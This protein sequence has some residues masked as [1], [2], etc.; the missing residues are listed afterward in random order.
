MTAGIALRLGQAAG[1]LFTRGEADLS[2]ISA[3]SEARSH[4]VSYPGS[5][6]TAQLV[7]V[8][9][10]DTGDLSSAQNFAGRTIAVV[11]AA[12]PGNLVADRFPNAKFETFRNNTEMVLAV[13]QGRADI[14]VAW[15]HDAVYAIEANLPG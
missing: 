3:W 11:A 14:G 6:L 2:P 13:S 8:A 12:V 1:L 4:F 5:L 10:R 15:Q 9:R 7:L